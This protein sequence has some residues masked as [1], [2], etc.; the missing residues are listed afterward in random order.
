VV[1]AG[2][3]G[4]MGREVIKAVI[5]DET[6]EL[7]GAVDVR[8]RG[9]DLGG[10]V[11]L[12]PLGVVISNDLENLLKNIRPQVMVDFSNPQSV[13]R[14]I[15]LAI[16]NNVCPV[17]GTTGLT[18]EEIQDID[19]KAKAK[20]IGVFIAPNFA[21]GAVLMMKFAREAVRYFPHVEIIEMH[22]DQKVDAPS[23]T[24]LR[25]VD[26]I[27]EQRSVFRQGAIN[28]YEKVSGARGAEIDGIRVH[29]VRLPG[30]VAHEEVIF[31][32]LGQILTL[33]HDSINRECFM[34][35]VL[36]AVHKVSH[37][38]GLVVGLEH[39]LDD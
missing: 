23:G 31:G 22:H 2:A 26:L 12:P 37:L 10:L 34:P 15:Y 30:Y 16:D 27:R 19:T 11:G 4:K 17:V 39:L 6:L 25:T 36:V 1:V 33:R 21:L 14:N 13:L 29:S 24:S 3:Y 5:E 20:G 28:E 9:T 8:G 38:K 32:G 35:G 18:T 7:V